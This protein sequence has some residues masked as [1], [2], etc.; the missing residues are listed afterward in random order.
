MMI[1]R[2]CNHKKKILYMYVYDMVVVSLEVLLNTLVY[3]TLI[4]E[5]TLKSIGPMGQL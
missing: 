5:D 2:F 4:V 1:W 3:S